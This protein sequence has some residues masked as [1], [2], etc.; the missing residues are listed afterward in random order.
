MEYAIV[1]IET[2]GGFSSGHRITDIAIYIHDG[3]K[4]ID[5]FSTL[6]NPERSIPPFITM[7]TGISNEMVQDAPKFYE[8]AREIYEITQDRVFVAHNVGFDYSFIREEFK[9]LGGNFNRRKLCTVRLSREILPGLPSYSLGKLCKSLDIEIKARHRAHG[10]ALATA[11]LWTM[12]MEND[13]EDFIQYSMNPHHRESTLPPNLSKGAFDKIPEE[14][15]VYYFHAE[16]GTVLYVGKAKNLRKRVIS[17]FTGHQFTKP[18]LRERIHDI[19]YELCGSELVSL[20]YE[21]DEIKRL[22][23]QYNRAQKRTSDNFGITSYMDR[24]GYLRL[25]I[26]RLKNISD[27][28]AVFPNHAD[29]H[30]FLTHFTEENHLCPKMTGLQRSPTS[31]FDYRIKK[32][33]GACCGKEMPAVYNVRA[34]DSIDKLKGLDSTFVIVEQGRDFEEVGIVLVEHGEYIGFGFAHQDDSFDNLD[35]V[36]DIITEY[37]DNRDIQRILQTYLKKNKKNAVA[38]NGSSLHLKSAA[39]H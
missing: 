27:P 26:E 6:I 15:G 29:A 16:D 2:T 18:E 19:S 36:K 34:Q 37:T 8:V 35:A 30:T 4:I 22:W 1:D 39:I 13:K 38:I 14:N 9:S 3:E 25:G 7:L 5:E 32:C 28:L 33:K 20:L 23:P 12:L 11:E 21:S 31:C 10:D 24:K 17:H